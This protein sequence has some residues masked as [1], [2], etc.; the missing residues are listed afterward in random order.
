MDKPPFDGSTGGTLRAHPGLAEARH[1]YGYAY[2][3]ECHM[4][5]ASLGN[6]KKE[7]DPKAQVEVE[8]TG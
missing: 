2:G 1:T 4:P 7:M 3:T 8:A 5:H 6:P